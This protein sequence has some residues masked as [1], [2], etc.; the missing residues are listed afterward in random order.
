MVLVSGK[1]AS[2][3]RTFCT[4]RALHLLVV[5]VLPLYKCSWQA[6]VDSFFFFLEILRDAFLWV[7]LALSKRLKFCIILRLGGKSLPSCSFLLLALQ[8]FPL[9]FSA[10]KVH[11]RGSRR[12]PYLRSSR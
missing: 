6:V 5:F 1:G 2:V 11:Y 8:P 9:R 7:L 3:G 12:Y 4:V 10:M